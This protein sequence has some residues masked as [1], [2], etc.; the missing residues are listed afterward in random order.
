MGSRPF[1]RVQNSIPLLSLP[2]SASL[3]PSLVLTCQQG[4]KEILKEYL[5]P[6]PPR[7]LI[8]RFAHVI[9]DN[10]FKLRPAM[11]TL[12]RSKAFYHP[13]YNDTLPKNSVEFAVEAIKV[14]GLENNYDFSGTEYQMQKLGMQVN[15]A[16]SVFWFN[17]AAWTSSAIAIERSN[18]VAQLIGDSTSLNKTSPA[19]SASSVLPTGASSSKDRRLRNGHRAMDPV[20]RSLI[21]KKESDRTFF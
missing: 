5:T 11:A 9:Q 3:S 20:P 2:L 18:L 10:N 4:A 13:F 17:P 1:F 6:D 8:E 12:F 15:Q 7:E 14:L 19:W 21:E 16:P